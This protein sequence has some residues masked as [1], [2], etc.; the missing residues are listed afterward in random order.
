MRRFAL[1]ER[2]VEC[3]SDLRRLTFREMFGVFIALRARHFADVGHSDRA[4]TDYALFRVCFP[5][6]RRGYVGSMNPMLWRGASLFNR[7]ETGHPDSVFRDF[8]QI[9]DTHGRLPGYGSFTGL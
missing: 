6:Y 9:F 7:A 8:G 5:Q 1:P 4:D 3:G 2:A